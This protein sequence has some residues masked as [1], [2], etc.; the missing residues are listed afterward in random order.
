MPDVI[1]FEDTFQRLRQTYVER[2]RHSV[3]AIDN[4][5]SQK[6]LAPLSA[7][8]L[9]R[10]VNLFHG[11]AGS[12]T[13]F[14]FPQVSESALKIEFSSNLVIGSLGEYDVMSEHQYQTFETMAQ[15]FAP[16]LRARV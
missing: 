6:Q 4:V 3:E 8:D 15:D 1:S 10:A 5:L 11:L 14:G 13:T 12:G 7:E 2:L 16:D 9:K